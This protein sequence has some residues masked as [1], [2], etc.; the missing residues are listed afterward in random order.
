MKVVLRIYHCD[1]LEEG[2]LDDDFERDTAE[3][4]APIFYG[5]PKSSLEKTIFNVQSFL[6]S[7]LEWYEGQEFLIIFQLPE[8]SKKELHELG[9]F[10]SMKLEQKSGELW[11]FSQGGDQVMKTLSFEVQSDEGYSETSPYSRNRVRSH[12]YWQSFSMN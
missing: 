3:G 11:S 10:F 12:Q 6:T 8:L 7:V 5:F 9:L 4:K 1:D 2:D